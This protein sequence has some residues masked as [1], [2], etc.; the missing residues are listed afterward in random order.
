MLPVPLTAKL[1]GGVTLKGFMK[2]KNITYEEAVVIYNAYTSMADLEEKKEAKTARPVATAARAAPKRASRNPTPE[3]AA[4]AEPEEPAE[5]A[6]ADEPPAPVTTKASKRKLEEP[7]AARKSNKKPVVQQEPEVPEAPE[8]P[9][10]PKAKPVKRTLVFADEEADATPPPVR[11]SKKRAL[12]DAEAKTSETMNPKRSNAIPEIAT[13]SPSPR[14][15]LK[16]QWNL[17]FILR[18]VLRL[19]VPVPYIT[20][21]VPGVKCGSCLTLPRSCGTLSAGEMQADS[22][23]GKDLEPEASSPETSVSDMM[24]SFLGCGCDMQ[25]AVQLPVDQVYGQVLLKN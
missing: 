2:A 8:A 14:G 1:P 4:E 7:K 20:N 18:M 3:Q 12:T 21:I 11:I 25:P 24:S 15:I 22:S 10:A 5:E 9:T 19:I 23:M 17:V 13:P 16:K 6:E